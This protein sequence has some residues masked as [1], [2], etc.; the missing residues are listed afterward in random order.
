[1][2]DYEDEDVNNEELAEEQ[3]QD[4]QGTKVL[5]F[6]KKKHDHYHGHGHSSQKEAAENKAKFI[7]SGTVEVKKLVS[8][9]LVAFKTYFLK[10]NDA[11]EEC[12]VVQYKKESRNGLRSC[13]VVR[14]DGTFHKVYIPEEE[15]Q[16]LSS[17]SATSFYVSKV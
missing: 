16:T 13:T 11:F 5:L 1:M 8:P 4:E 17:G 9:L 2:S 7:A 15:F 10:E 12:L 3:E 6:Q 14:Q